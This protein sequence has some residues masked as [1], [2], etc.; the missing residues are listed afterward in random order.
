MAITG[1][2]AA[3]I[4]GALFTGAVLGPDGRETP[5]R[6]VRQ[7]EEPGRYWTIVIVHA[8]LLALTLCAVVIRLAH[9]S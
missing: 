2:L 3:L 4:G 9:S 8:A 5:V 7:A 1:L 6:F